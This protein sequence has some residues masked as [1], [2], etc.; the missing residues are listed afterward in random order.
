MSDLTAA[1]HAASLLENVAAVAASRAETLP[2]G[3]E[4]SGLV[5]AAD[6]WTALAAA[7]TRGAD[8]SANLFGSAVQIADADNATAGVYALPA[9]ADRLLAAYTA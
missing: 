6:R 3:T 4:R 2:L 9:Q 5:A 1:A 8:L 7:V